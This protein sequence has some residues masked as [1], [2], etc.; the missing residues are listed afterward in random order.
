MR[1]S[2]KKISLAYCYFLL[3]LI[4]L[5]FAACKSGGKS[6]EGKEKSKESNGL[7]Q[8]TTEQVEANNLV[9]GHP[10]EYL[11]SGIAGATGYLEALPRNRVIVSAVTDGVIGELNLLPGDRVSRGEILFHI[12]NQE[13]LQIQ[14][15]FMTTSA[16]LKYQQ[17]EYERQ[18]L[19]VAENVSAGKSF[20]K[21]ESDYEATKARVS[22]LEEQLNLLHISLKELKEGKM[23]TSVAVTSPISGYVTRVEQ[24]NGKYVTP[25][26]A[27]LEVTGTSPLM[28]GLRVFEKDILNVR[29]GQK[30]TFS[31][32][33]A[34]AEVFESKIVKTG[35]ALDENRTVKVYALFNPSRDSG[36]LP[37]MFV[38]AEITT[39]TFTAVALP[40]SAIIS[41]EGAEFVLVRTNSDPGPWILKKVPVVTGFREKEMVEIKPESRISLSDQIV[42]SGA[43]SVAN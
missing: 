14:E 21:A 26:S 12:R 42:I 16:L 32:P 38:K 25:E 29:E 20:Q 34:T 43:F 7:L 27:V 31:V 40:L 28:I 8:L 37:G 10:L 3:V 23:V 36:L 39:G 19:L 13:L 2:N 9:L 11:F 24:T 30:V 33:D 17:E 6:D 15:D 35:K 18:K 22:S 1:S 4:F 5:S 41:G